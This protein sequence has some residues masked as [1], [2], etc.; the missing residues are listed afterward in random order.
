MLRD[1]QAN[2]VKYGDYHV[3]YLYVEDE[4]GKLVGV[5]RMHDLLFADAETILRSLMI[6]GPLKLRTEATIDELRQFFDEHNLFG[7][8]IV[9][10]LDRLVGVVL[11]EDVEEASHKEA[12]RQYLGF[13]GI[14]GG[15]EFRTMPI[16]LRSGRRFSWLSINIVL[17]IIAASII[18][19]YTDT[20]SAVIAI[21]FYSLS[22]LGVRSRQK[23]KCAY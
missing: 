22:L 19:L 1:L 14:I 11:P 12:D 3:Q 15:E 18:A 4:K 23:F 6:K 2:R 8:P 13:S 10:N 21:V 20:L 7:V 17:N 16:M 5:L 9:D